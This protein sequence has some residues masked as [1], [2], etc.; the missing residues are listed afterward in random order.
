MSTCQYGEGKQVLACPPTTTL[1]GINVLLANGIEGEAFPPAHTH[2]AQMGLFKS[3]TWNLWSQVAKHQWVNSLFIHCSLRRSGTENVNYS[4]LYC[5][6][7]APL[8]P[9]FPEGEMPQT[10]A[11][12]EIQTGQSNVNH[13]CGSKCT[14][15]LFLSFFLSFFLFSFF[16]GWTFGEG[17]SFVFLWN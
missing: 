13:F 17:A 14:Q 16:F 15:R 4:E 12:L 3:L 2:T 8:G 10:L 1:V 5:M 6:Y 11:S 7:L 9:L